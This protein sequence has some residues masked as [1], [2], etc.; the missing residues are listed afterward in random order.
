MIAF[1]LIKA[2]CRISAPS[3]IIVGPLI[4]ALLA[5]FALLEIHIFSPNLSYC[6]GDKVSPNSIINSDIFGITSQG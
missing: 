4:F 2:Q 3:Q 1:P 6:S 5:I